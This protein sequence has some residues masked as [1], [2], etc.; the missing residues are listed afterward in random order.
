MID[1]KV[2]SYV[3][4]METPQDAANSGEVKITKDYENLFKELDQTRL[5][6]IELDKSGSATTGPFHSPSFA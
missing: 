1:K 4:Y 3:Y 6:S 2:V 5:L